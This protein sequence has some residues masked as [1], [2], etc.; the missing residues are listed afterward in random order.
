MGLQAHEISQVVHNM[1]RLEEFATKT[2]EAQDV[3]L[4]G[5]GNARAATA[6][7]GVMAKEAEFVSD[8]SNPFRMCRTV[9]KLARE[10]GKPV[11]GALTQLKLAA[12]VAVDDTFNTVLASDLCDSE[13]AKV[14]EL[15]SYGREYITEL[16]RGVI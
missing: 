15:Q 1:G 11:P 12:A 16:L 7:Y 14:A 2:A 4:I 10:L 8:G 5:E 6:L 13:K 3:A 9:V